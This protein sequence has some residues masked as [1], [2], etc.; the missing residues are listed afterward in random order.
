MPLGYPSFAGWQ[1]EL[2]TS[3][4]VVAEDELEGYHMWQEA[5]GGYF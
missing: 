1:P 3:G 5:K 2:I 4:S